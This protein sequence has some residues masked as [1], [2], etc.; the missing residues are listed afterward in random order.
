[1]KTMLLYQ[2]VATVL[3]PPKKEEVYLNLMRRTSADGGINLVIFDA[4]D[5]F[6]KRKGDLLS[7]KEHHKVAFEL[8]W[9]VGVI[10]KLL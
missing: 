7:W 4:D 9:I 1:M 2:P 6:E 8:F 5:D 3:F 10:M